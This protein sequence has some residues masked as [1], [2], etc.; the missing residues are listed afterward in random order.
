MVDAIEAARVS[1]RGLAAINVSL[2]AIVDLILPFP[3]PLHNAP[4]RASGRSRLIAVTRPPE[5]LDRGTRDRRGPAVVTP[6]GTLP[7]GAPICPGGAPVRRRNYRTP[8]RNFVTDGRIALLSMNAPI[9]DSPGSEKN[10]A[11]GI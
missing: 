4:G 6:M 1:G 11:F 2:P 9:C 10:R 5:S 8:P 3:P 7:T